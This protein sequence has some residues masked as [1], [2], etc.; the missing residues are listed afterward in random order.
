MGFL[1]TSS[2]YVWFEDSAV[3]RMKKEVFEMTPE[4]VDAGLAEYGIPSPPEWCKPGSYIQTTTRYKVIENRRKNDI[5]LIPVG[6]SENHGMHSPMAEDTLFCTSICEAVRRYSEKKGNPVNIALPPWNYGVHPYHHMGMPGTVL[7]REDVAKEQL[8]DVM[9]GLWNDGFRKQIII[10]NHGQLWTIE[11]AVQQFCKRYQLPGI[12]RCMD[13]HRAVRE[14]FITKEQGGEY[15]TP[16]SHADEA[17]TSMGLL[18][19]PEMMDMSK[20]VSTTQPQ[21][22]P[23]G[24]M[25]TSV[26]FYHRPSKWSECQGHIPLELFGCPEGVVGAAKSATV[27]KAKKPMLAIVR[28]ITLLCEEILKEYPAGTV[29]PVEKI[30]MRTEKEMAP[31]LK[32]PQS[33]G[34]KSVYCLPSVGY[35]ER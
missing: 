5:V 31:F 15:E 7:I 13:W 24:H 6:C 22:L 29:P 35:G 4:Q 33:P 12:F 14:L 28:Y 19:F 9:L 18:L 8:M 17:E 23:T 3:G 16:F 2:D 20:A 34:W 11:A 25:D 21:L 1:K 26:D 32:E 30:T 10:N 27:D